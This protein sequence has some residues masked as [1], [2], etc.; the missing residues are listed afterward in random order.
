MVS[1]PNA[2]PSP[3]DARPL[4]REELQQNFD[5]MMALAQQ[6]QNQ[7]QGKIILPK[8]AVIGGVDYSGKP[9]DDVLAFM[10]SQL[11]QYES[12]A[13]VEAAAAA[14]SQEP[15]PAGALPEWLEGHEGLI[16]RGTTQSTLWQADATQYGNEVRIS[17]SRR[18][19]VLRPG[20][21]VREQDRTLQP[22]NDVFTTDEWR[23]VK[24]VLDRYL[25]AEKD[26]EVGGPRAEAAR[27]LIYD[28]VREENYFKRG[29]VDGQPTR[30]AEALKQALDDTVKSVRG[31]KRESVDTDALV[32][33]T[34]DVLSQLVVLNR[35]RLDGQSRI[36]KKKPGIKENP[37]FRH[38][39]QKLV[40]CFEEQAKHNKGMSLIIG[41]A[42]TG[43]NEVVEY[44]AACTN[45]PFFWFPC[46]KGMEA[47][48]LVN[49]YEF[50]TKE[51]TQRFFTTLAQGLQTPGSVVFIDEVNALRPE[52]QAAFHGLGD[53]NRKLSFDGVEIPVAEGV[54]IIIGGNPATYA[55][56]GNIGQALLNRTRGQSMVMDYP[57]F[58]KSDVLRREEGHS[59]AVIEQM[60]KNN[61]SLLDVTADEVLI[62]FP[63][64]PEFRTLTDAQFAVLW[65]C[66]VNSRAERMPEALGDETLSKLVN[67][68]NVKKTL[69]D[70]KYILTIANQWRIGY[71][72][73]DGFDIGLSI[74]DTMAVVRRYAV[75]RDV[76]KAYLDIFD[77]FRKNP[78]ADLDQ[79]HATLVKKIDAILAA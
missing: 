40:R 14:E 8:G 52:V 45:R 11:D 39:L 49:H 2:G 36:P 53:G 63:E 17:Y 74:R 22:I 51:G 57:A 42:G 23:V 26:L 34:A 30:I 25:Q 16:W 1:M 66:I 3:E 5:A 58:T 20:K 9:L 4:S 44:F 54:L 56:A 38:G 28:V 79:T 19:K 32:Q 37:T 50:D 46:G 10:R 65:D 70:L 7:A 72:K 64:L 75:T 78:V 60:E 12:P 68:D 24:R 69:S 48:D 43:K 13:D 59:D 15:R 29:R 27:K 62:L 35:S 55:S 67:D 47:P 21:T 76:R 18:D 61:N 77:D 6:L 73:L 41:E 33:R 31:F 71:S